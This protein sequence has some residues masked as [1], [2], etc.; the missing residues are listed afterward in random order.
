M[1][2]YHDP[3]RPKVA[4]EKLNEARAEFKTIS[5]R[6]PGL[7]RAIFRCRLLALGGYGKI[8]SQR[9]IALEMSNNIVSLR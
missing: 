3:E 7:A 6:D 5:G 1:M 4:E 8:L 9:D 2:S